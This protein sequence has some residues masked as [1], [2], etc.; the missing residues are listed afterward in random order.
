MPIMCVIEVN[1]N[2][3]IAKY[4]VQIKDQLVYVIRYDNTQLHG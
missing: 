2:G 1:R 4:I 3:N